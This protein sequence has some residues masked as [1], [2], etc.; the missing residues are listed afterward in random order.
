[1]T[2]NTTVLVWAITE[3]GVTLNAT[4][5]WTRNTSGSAV[6]DYPFAPP[7]PPARPGQS[8]GQSAGNGDTGPASYPRRQTDTLVLYH[9]GHEAHWLGPKASE[10]LCVRWMD[11]QRGD[12]DRVPE[13]WL[14]YDTTLGWINELG[15]DAME[16]NMPL[17]GP[18]NNG[19][20]GT[21][22]HRYFAPLEAAGHHPLRFFVE[23][24]FL[25]VNF[26][27]AQGY[28]RIA[29]IGLSGGGW[30][31]TVAAGLDPR[32]GVPASCARPFPRSISH[33]PQ[34]NTARATRPSYPKLTLPPLLFARSKGSLSRS[35]DQSRS[36]CG[37]STPATRTTISATLSS[38]GLAQ[39]M[40]PATIAACMGWPGWSP[41]GHSFRFYTRTTRAV[42]QPG[43][44]AGTPRSWRT[45]RRSRPSWP[46]PAAAG[47]APRRRL[48]TSTKSTSVTRQ[49][50]GRCWISGTAPP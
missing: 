37:P 43:D 17:R 7:V 14:N 21:M 45:T 33:V 47:C 11:A 4:V 18:N 36:R 49:S 46:R 28:K 13:C 39:S 20:I 32:I 5:F 12:P 19:S 6:A 44:R 23:P 41:V 31:T 34:A 42:S 3:G 40:M 27:K 2:K 8:T 1:M 50:S 26:A 29:M 16:F 9:N 15:Y 38:S 35:R 48:G 25:A 22:S 24:V 10:P 30:T